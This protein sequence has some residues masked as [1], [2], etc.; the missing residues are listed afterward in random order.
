MDAANEYRRKLELPPHEPWQIFD[1][2]CGTSTG[3]LIAIMLGRLRMSIAE[4]KNAYMDLAEKAFTPRNYFRQKAATVTV[5]SKFQTKPLEDAIKHIIGDNWQSM[6]LKEDDPECKVF[7]VA[8]MQD[9]NKE[10]VLRNYRSFR[11]PPGSLHVMHIWEAC[12]AT[13]AALTFFEPIKVDDTT[14][15]DGGLL[16]NNPVQLVHGEASEMFEKREQMIV[17]L[18]T[19]TAGIPEKFD[20]RLR[21]VAY[22]LAKIAAETETTANN[23][24]RRDD[25]AAAEFGRYFRFNVPGIGD[26][27]MD[28]SKRLKEIKDLTEAYLEAAEISKKVISC[29]KQLAG[30]VYTVLESV[31]DQSPLPGGEED[32]QRATV[33]EYLK[34]RDLANTAILQI[35]LANRD[36]EQQ[37]SPYLV[38]ALLRQ[39]TEQTPHLSPTIAEWYDRHFRAG[40]RPLTKDYPPMIR[41]EAARFERI[42]IIIDGLDECRDQTRLDLLNLV[43]QVLESHVDAHLLVSS[44]PVDGVGLNLKEA[45]KLDMQAEPNDLGLYTASCIKQM[46]N[47]QKLTTRYPELGKEI[48]DKVT[49]KAGGMFLL[50]KLHLQ[51]LESSEKRTKTSFREFLCDL[52]LALDDTHRDVWLQIESQG[53]GKFELAKSVLTWVCYSREPLEATA[54]RHALFAAQT[55]DLECIDDEDLEDPNDLVQVCNGLVVRHKEN[56]VI[57]FEHYTAEEFFPSYLANTL[58]TAH[59]TI[60]RACLRYLSLKG[61]KDTINFVLAK[62]TLINSDHW[63]HPYP[64]MRYAATS[65]GYHAKRN[66]IDRSMSPEFILEFLRRPD[67]VKIAA[68]VLD[69]HQLP[70]AEFRPRRSV[71]GLH[72][73]SFFGLRRAVDQLISMKPLDLDISDSFGWSALRWACYGREN[74]IVKYL[75]ECGANISIMD[76]AG[77]TPLMWA[78]GK[79]ATHTFYENLTITTKPLDSFSL[80]LDPE[81]LST[82]SSSLDSSAKSLVSDPA[83]PAEIFDNASWKSHDVTEQPHPSSQQDHY[84]NK[85]II[86]NGAS[87]VKISEVYFIEPGR[88]QDLLTPRDSPV[89]LRTSAEIVDLLIRHSGES[90][91]IRGADT[92]TALSLAAENQQFDIV[93]K[94]LCE[95]AEIESSDQHNSI[96]PLLWVLQSPRRYSEFGNLAI[97]GPVVAHLGFSII[98]LS[99]EN[100][101]DTSY[102]AVTGSQ[103]AIA[104]RLIGNNTNTVDF[105]SRTALSLSA[106]SGY[107]EVVDALIRRNADVNLADNQGMT[108]LMYASGHFSPLKISYQDV[109]VEDNAFVI[110]GTLIHGGNGRNTAQ[111]RADSI[112]ARI[113]IINMLLDAGA[114]IDRRSNDGSTALDLAKQARWGVISSMLWHRSEMYGPELGQASDGDSWDPVARTVGA[115]NTTPVQEGFDTFI[116]AESQAHKHFGASDQ[117]F[118][119]LSFEDS[120]VMVG[121]VWWDKNFFESLAQRNRSEEGRAAIRKELGMPVDAEILF[122][123]F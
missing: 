39:L 105:N 46:A 79:R 104:L 98:V 106:E 32:A 67:L 89:L 22:Q 118:S 77:N 100:Q 58:P 88:F 53:S 2:I 28:E 65:W 99:G 110:F 6:L 70:E 83:T 3:G 8:H 27:D 86:S 101:V 112:N 62:Y 52:P 13:S 20:P 96:T 19:G 31:P 44:R 80:D 40:T 36:Q 81:T 66:E 5:G 76:R 109:T 55:K 123:G 35:Y 94:L 41:F 33:F 113:T 61:V 103:Q 75:I 11:Y 115:A 119:R 18:G 60:A 90:I 15:S 116:P 68:R 23:F 12:R 14:Y 45:V 87:P 82:A 10:A 48:Q 37:T 64:L 49:V 17:S 43:N 91:N 21:T 7:V 114:S 122:T 29:A 63:D 16:Y 72:L 69:V 74:A 50:A 97:R 111:I 1:M 51:L 102:T 24:F 30:G 42:Y 71:I 84:R 57:Q 9:A 95:G 93:N 47:L 120:T 4:C 78:L 107:V 59:L 73:A 108:P 38:P 121:N 85:T 56:D 54:L 25:G 117:K 92:R 26:I 34:K